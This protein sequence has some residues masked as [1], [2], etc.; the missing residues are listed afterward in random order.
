MSNVY[1]FV[2][3][4]PQNKRQYSNKLYHLLINRSVA[5]ILILDKCVYGFFFN[6]QN[7][8][9]LN[10]LDF[11]YFGFERTRRWLFQKCDIYILI[12]I[13]ASIPLVVDYYLVP[14]TINRPVVSVSALTLFI[15]YIYYRN[16]KFLNNVVMIKTKVLLPQA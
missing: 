1:L 11:Q 16:L 13:T 7:S 15:R 10:Y 9:V 3:F 12:T 8:G 6:W 4:E 5:L 2:L 14:E